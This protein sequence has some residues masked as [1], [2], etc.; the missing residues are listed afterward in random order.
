[1]K[2]EKFN[3]INLVRNLII[4]ID[5]NL[6]NFPKSDIEIKNRIRNLGYSL[7]GNEIFYGGI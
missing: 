3:A 7:K 2:Q 4:R 5:N 6:D 1:M